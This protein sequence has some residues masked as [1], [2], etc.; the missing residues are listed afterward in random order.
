MK[1]KTR[2]NLAKILIGVLV[3]GIL[4]G[5]GYAIYRV[6]YAQGFTVGLAETLGREEILSTLGIRFPSARRGFIPVLGL[7]FLRLLVP[8]FLLGG[9]LLMLGLVISLVRRKQHLPSRDGEKD[10]EQVSPGNTAPEI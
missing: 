9:I 2:H 10:L 5:V 3:V 6:G 8:V 1:G 7:P 4:V